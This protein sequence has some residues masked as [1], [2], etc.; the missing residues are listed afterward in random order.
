[1]IFPLIIFSAKRKM[2]PKRSLQSRVKKY[3]TKQLDDPTRYK[4]NIEKCDKKLIG[5]TMQNLVSHARVHKDFFRKT[6]EIDAATEKEMP[7]RRLQ[8]IQNWT[9]MVT[10]NGQPFAV[11]S[12]S[13]FRKSVKHEVDYLMEAGYGQGLSKPKCRA[14]R[15]YIPR[16]ASAIMNQ[17]KSEVRHK[18]VSLMIDT[19]TKFQKSILGLNCQYIIDSRVVIRSIGMIPLQTSHTALHIAAA[20]EERLQCFGITTKQLISITT[21]NASNMQALVERFNVAFGEETA[22]ADEESIGNESGDD[23]MTDENELI[24]DETNQDME[25][26][27]QPQLVFTNDEEVSTFIEQVVDEMELNETECN[28]DLLQLLGDQPD[29]DE[30]LR[31]LEEILA[32]QGL[33]INNI[34]CAAHTLQMAVKGAISVAEFKNLIRLCRAVCKELRKNSNQLELRQN[35]ISFQTPGLDCKTRWDSIYS[36]VC[37]YTILIISSSNFSNFNFQCLIFSCS[38]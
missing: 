5:T 34:R 6:F 18:F 3:F 11:L 14:V 2:A 1:M 38:T 13:G 35:K 8:L 24:A 28:D 37:G 27:F 33:N 26:N 32:T 36:M 10:V 29:C 9:E 15:D 20:I 25:I 31:D 30:L 16:V 17:I 4:C 22:D 12:K 21:D 23:A 7:A 19:A